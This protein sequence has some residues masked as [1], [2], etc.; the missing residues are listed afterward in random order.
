MDDID[1]DIVRLL[2]QDGR[3]SN[4]DLADA[5]RLSPSPTLRRVRRLEEDG[6]IAGYTALVDQRAWGLPVTCFVQIRL[7]EHNRAA[8]EAFEQAVQQ[9]DRIQECFLMT[10]EA[11][12]L[13]R[14]VAADLE[15]YEDFVRSTLHQMPGIAS[16]GTGFAYGV[17][18]RTP[19]LPVPRPQAR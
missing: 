8:V 12:Y 14:V 7:S 1:R 2:Q 11:D 15:D 16:I 19:A 6:V 3:L 9:V 17:V 4:Q 10:G 13:L 5:I 18:K